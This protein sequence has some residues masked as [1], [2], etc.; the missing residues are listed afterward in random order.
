MHP[1]ITPADLSTLIAE[2]DAAACRLRRK[3]VLPAVDHDDLRQDLLVDL[4]CRLPGF[5]A[6]RGSIGAFAN[7]VLRNQSSRIAMRHHRQRRAQGGSILSLAVPLAGAREPVGDTLT[8]DDGLAAWHGQTCCAAAVTE[9][10]H[11]LQAA[12][13]RLPAEDRRFC[14]AL[15][16]RPVSALA[17]EGFGSR[18][19]LYRRLADL[20]HVLTAHG[21]GPAWDDLAAA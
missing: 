21:L 16:H 7:I 15:A 8:E 6:R 5:D 11:T 12:L 13:A 17:A 18:S 2:A 3:L 10:H 20:R 4:I 9:L 1:P 19:A 14:A